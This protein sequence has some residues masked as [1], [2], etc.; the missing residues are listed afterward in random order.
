MDKVREIQKEIK[1]FQKFQLFSQTNF[2]LFSSFSLIHS[3]SHPSKH[4]S[5]CICLQNFKSNYNFQFCFL[6]KIIQKN[7]R[8]FKMS[9]L[10]TVTIEK[11]LPPNQKIITIQSSETIPNALKV[12]FLYFFLAKN[13]S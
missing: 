5:F 11:L 4:L 12:F 10:D 13:E 9:L 8:T 6:K 2:F 7:F 1:K 3:Q